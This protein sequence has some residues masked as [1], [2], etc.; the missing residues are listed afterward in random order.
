MATK[1]NMDWTVELFQWD[2]ESGYSL[3]RHP[4]PD[5]YKRWEEAADAAIEKCCSIIEGSSD[6]TGTGSDRKETQSST[7]ETSENSHRADNPHAMGHPM[8]G[9]HSDEDPLIYE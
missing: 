5:S 3:K 2:G 8:Y 6:R 4:M 1:D 7:R 9:R